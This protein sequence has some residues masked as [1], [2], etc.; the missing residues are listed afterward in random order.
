MVNTNIRQNLQFFEQNFIKMLFTEKQRCCY[1]REITNQFFSVTLIREIIYKTKA[2][3]NKMRLLMHVFFIWIYT[4]V[5]IPIFPNLIFPT[6]IFIVYV[7]I[8]YLLLNIYLNY[9]LCTF[10]CSLFSLFLLIISF[11]LFS[12]FFFVSLFGFFSCLVLADFDF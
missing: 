12:Q 8:F 10:I 4:S 7:N 5:Y 1:F 2:Y 6:Q 3:N 9:S 11:F